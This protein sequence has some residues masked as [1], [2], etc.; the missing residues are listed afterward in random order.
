MAIPVITGPLYFNSLQI[1]I[2]QDYTAP[3]K[4]HDQNNLGIKGLIWLKLPGKCVSRREVRAGIWRQELMQRR[5]KTAFY[6]LAPRGLLSLLSYKTQ[7]HQPR[8]DISH[9]RLDPL[10]ST[11]LLITNNIINLKKKS[12]IHFPT[13]RSYRGILLI[14]N[15]SSLITTTSIKLT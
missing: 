13:T 5:E 7:N 15:P 3:V 12:P 6:G 14:E 8:D 4:H 9:N 1:H 10:P 11:N 2:S